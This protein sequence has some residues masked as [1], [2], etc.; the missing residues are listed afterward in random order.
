ML[1]E[2]DTNW[3]PGFVN[4]NLKQFFVNRL[5]RIWNMLPNEVVSVTGSS[6]GS[7]KGHLDGFWCDLDLYYN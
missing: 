6:V 7:F 5:V 4:M 3:S 1:V 2:I